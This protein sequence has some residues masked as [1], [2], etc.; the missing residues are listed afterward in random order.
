MLESM[1]GVLGLPSQAS[2]V[3]AIVDADYSDKMSYLERFGNLLFSLA[4][5]HTF[6]RGWKA[7]TDVFRKHFGWV[8]HVRFRAICNMFRN[9]FP[10]VADIAKD[11]ALTIVSTGEFVE[12]PRPVTHNVVYIGGLGLSNQS[13][14][15]LKEPF[16]SEME[17][18]RNGVVF[19]SFGSSTPTRYFPDVVKR[20]MIK[21][22]AELPDYHFIMKIDK[23]DEVSTLRFCSVMSSPIVGNSRV[24]QTAS[25]HLHN[26]VGTTTVDPR[27]VLA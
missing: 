11:S 24:S 10:H 7:E 23:E 12:F 21:A 18:G 9:D 13:A 26:H 6:S 16:L 8:W 25:E 5:Y 15:V 3:P 20:N 2:Y 4:N 17:K 27:F 19:I 14:A 22:I 1:N